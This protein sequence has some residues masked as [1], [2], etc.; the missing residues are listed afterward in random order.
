M[1]DWIRFIWALIVIYLF[2]G[3][4]NIIQT[5][6]ELAKQEHFPKKKKQEEQVSHH[7]AE[8]VYHEIVPSHKHVTHYL[9]TPFDLDWNLH[10][11]NAQYLTA[12]ELG[13]VSYFLT[14]GLQTR[15]RKLKVNPLLMGVSFQFR[16]DVG[17]FT[18]IKLETQVI[19]YDDKFMYFEQTL[20]TGKHQ[21][22]GRGIARVG[23][24]QRGKGLLSSQDWI[25]LLPTNSKSEEEMKLAEA[26]HL[27]KQIE[28]AKTFLRE[29][30]S[31]TVSVDE[32]AQ[33]SMAKEVL[34]RLERVKTFAA[35]DLTLKE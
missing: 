21:H 15:A 1:F 27:D 28:K 3:K 17:C 32:H 19:S 4:E 5:K 33:A 30:Q 20:S 7:H 24:A 8:D 10:M 16:K 26:M 11:N 9:V 22:I 31:Q 23:F 12:M 13:R 2:K 25:K 35:H 6:A 34:K 18:N 29:D 14:T